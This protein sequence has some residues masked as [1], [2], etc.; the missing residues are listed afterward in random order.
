MKFSGVE[1]IFPERAILASFMPES[2]LIQVLDDRP[3]LGISFGNVTLF[4]LDRLGGV[5]PG[6][7][8]FKLEG[9]MQS[10]ATPPAQ[11]LSFGGAWSNHLHALAQWGKERNVATVGVVRGERHEHLTPT[12]EDCIEWGMILEFVSRSDYRRRGDPNFLNQLIARYPG[13]VILPE[14]GASAGGM[15]GCTSIADLMLAAGIPSGPVL[16]A[17]GTGTTLAGI[18]LGFGRSGEA[19]RELIGISALRGAD[20]LLASIQAILI[21]R[22]KAARW[23]LLQEHHCGGFARVNAGLREF[24]LEFEAVHNV[25]LEP[26]YTG[27][28]LYAIHQLRSQGVWDPQ[29]SLV[30]IHTGGLQGRRGYPWLSSSGE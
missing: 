14:G 13:T 16:L 17:V 24:M 4:R 30:V 15:L 11:I 3:V 21:G 6:N 8:R 12:L 20:D 19:Q 18:A 9:C 23:Q 5:A 7:K 10:L 26:V 2:K 22:G 27:K 29:Q 1:L 28:V 25:F